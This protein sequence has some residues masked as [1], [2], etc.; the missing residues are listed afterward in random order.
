[1]LSSRGVLQNIK[2]VLKLASGTNKMSGL[3]Q[4]V[5]NLFYQILHTYTCQHC[6]TTDIHKSLFDGRGVLSA[7]ISK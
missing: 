1:M 3:E 6:L 5:E 4:R 2:K 7:V